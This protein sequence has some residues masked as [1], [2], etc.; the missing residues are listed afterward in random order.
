MRAQGL[1]F[2]CVKKLLKPMVA[3]YG[4]ILLF[5]KAHKFLS[6]YRK[7]KFIP[8]GAIAFFILLVLLGLFIWFAIYYLMLSRA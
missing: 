4:Y 2:L 1:D 6:A 5:K 7:E 8:K 3:K